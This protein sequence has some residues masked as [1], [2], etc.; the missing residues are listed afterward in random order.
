MSCSGLLQSRGLVERS[1]LTVKSPPAMDHRMLSAKLRSLSTLLVGIFL[2]SLCLSVQ[3]ALAVDFYHARIPVADQTASERSRAAAKGLREV[4]IRLSGSQDVVQAQGVGQ[5]LSNASSYMDQFQYA[6]ERDEWGGTKE[7]LDMTFAP[8]VIE[9]LL[10]QAGMPFWPIN[11]PK[12]L[13]WLVEDQVGEGKVLIN[14]RQ[15]PVAQSVL[16]AAEL[17]GLP[18]VLP[19]LDMEDQL[20]MP[21]EEVWAMNEEAIL[22]ASERYGVDT[23]LVGRFTQTS[24]GQWWST[25]Q[26]FHRGSGEVLDV[27]ADTPEEL[28]RQAIDPLADYLARLY[29]IVPRSEGSAELVLQIDAVEDFADYRGVLT[30]LQEHAALAQAELIMIND[31]MLTVRAALS[32]TMEQFRNAIALDGKLHLEVTQV[33]PSAPWIAVSEGTS[34]N[35]MRLRWTV[36]D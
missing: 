15:A 30:Y 29:A 31:Q 25:W 17:R 36:G 23:V 32:G 2:C 10:R 11:R 35:P 9:R 26:Y 21:A 34:A 27:R 16:H 14:D 33:A 8:A 4:L 13:V 12:T 1:A 5:A 28:G 24:A 18:L 19:L 7:F 20:A 3:R 6:H 22:N